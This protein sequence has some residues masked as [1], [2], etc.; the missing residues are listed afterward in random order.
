MINEMLGN[1]EK[2]V[3]WITS[4]DAVNNAASDN[5]GGGFFSDVKKGFAEAKQAYKELDK[6]MSNLDNLLTGGREVNTDGYIPLEVQYNPSSVRIYSTGKG[7]GGYLIG[8]NNVTQASTL[9]SQTIMDFE[10]I[11]EDIN[12]QDAFDITSMG[13]NVETIYGLGKDLASHLIDGPYGVINQVQGILGLIHNTATQGVIFMWND[14]VFKGKLTDV[15]IEYTMF[16]K[17]G[18][19]ILAKVKM[20]IQHV[21]T[22]DDDSEIK[23]W[24]GVIKKVFKKHEHTT[25]YR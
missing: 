8:S 16:N 17:D 22:K 7:S 11:F 5:Q 15:N 19:P 2:A 4:L 3:L 24:D 21:Y 13:F 25:T 12:N 18:D 10:L 20:S 23:Y 9:I 1:V 6:R 14:M